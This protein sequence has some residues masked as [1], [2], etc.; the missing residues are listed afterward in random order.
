MM[1]A[2]NDCKNDTGGGFDRQRVRISDVLAK[3]FWKVHTAIREHRYNHYWLAGGRGS[4]KSS[5]CSL[6]IP[7]LLI[8]N[9]QCNAVLLRKVGRTLKTSVY[10]QL[11]WAI[12]LLGLDDYFI[13]KASPL[14]IIY[15]PTGQKILFFGV[16]D[17]SKLKSIK[18]PRGY[19]G[20]VW[21][22]EADQFSGMEEIRSINQ[23]LLR[24]GERYWCFYSYNPPKSRDNWVNQETLIDEPD[25]LVHRSTYL[26]VPREWLGE[27]FF[28]EAEKLKA[29]NEMLYRH[30]Y[31][32][33][34]TGTGGAVFSNVEKLDMS[35]EM[36]A[37]FERLHD[38]L[39]FG[40]AVDPL[41]YTKSH[42]DA[43][44]EIIYVFDELVAVGM[45]N[46]E[47]AQ[48]ILPKV[49]S[50]R[51]ACD[52]AEPK[53]IADLKSFGIKAYGAKKGPDSVEYGIK[54]LQDRAKIYIDA[55]RAPHTYREFSS[56]E[57]QRNKDGLFVSVY[58]DKDNHTI[59]SMRYAYAEV[60][61]QSR[62]KGSI[63]KG[64]LGL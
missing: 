33:E 44:H 58:P 42:Y 23:S 52:A 11:Q 15:K 25:R 17:K 13:Q 14:E 20:I 34:V 16:D 32:G 19:V 57:Y 59:D 39:D 10:A 26:H 2:D 9:P 40:F 6:E 30:E 35:D 54:W 8:R 18:L 63:T 28:A 43:K 64:A 5:T 55:R 46:N 51:L 3:P 22:E 1:A 50:R 38:G 27:L 31:L 12:S 48:R 37:G 4:L 61:A 21:Y 62:R 56:Y 60:A 53:S 49:E 24:G 7:L 36:I 41:A 29:K 47:A 45:R